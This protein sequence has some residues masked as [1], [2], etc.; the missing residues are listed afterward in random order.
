MGGQGV[1]GAGAG[2]PLYERAAEVVQRRMAPLHIVPWRKWA[3]RPKLRA[4]V[5]KVRYGYTFPT[6]IFG[7][8]YGCFVKIMYKNFCAEQN[9]LFLGS[10]YVFLF[11]EPKPIVVKVHPIRTRA[12]PRGPIGAALL[13]T[14]VAARLCFRLDRIGWHH[15]RQV[16]LEVA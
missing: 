16:W 15:A 7:G 9:V 2:P 11:F 13:P 6:S 10:R 14:P 5:R 4:N 3:K 1:S 8:V 12:F